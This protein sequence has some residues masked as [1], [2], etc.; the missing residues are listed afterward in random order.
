MGSGSH[1]G[2]NKTCLTKPA[3]AITANAQIMSSIFYS[4]LDSYKCH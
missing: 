4:Q 1:K 3:L 2:L